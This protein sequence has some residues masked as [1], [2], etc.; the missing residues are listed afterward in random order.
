MRIQLRRGTATA[1]AV[2]NPT[3]AIG[4]PGFE[5]N[6][7][8]FKIGDGATAWAD[9]VYA[10]VIALSHLPGGSYAYRDISALAVDEVDDRISGL[11][12]GTTAQNLF[13]TRNDGA[14]S[15]VRSLTHFAADVDLTSVSVYASDGLPASTATLISPR[16]VLLAHH[17]VP[18]DGTVLRFVTAAD[19]V[20]LR[21]LSTSIRVGTTDIRIGRL[22]SDIPSALGFA[23]VLTPEIEARIL[24]APA[25]YTDQNQQ[26]FVGDITSLTANYVQFSQ[27]ST[28]PRSA[29]WKS[30][31]LAS[32]DSSHPVFVILDGEAVL[33]GA[34]QNIISPTVAR[35]PTIAQN[36]AAINA[37]MTTLGGGYQLTVF[38]AHGNVAVLDESNTFTERQRFDNGFDATGASANITDMTI[39]GTVTFDD[40]LSADSILTVAGAVLTPFIPAALQSIRRNAGNTAF[41]AF[42][43]A[44]LTTVP[45][46]ATATG[47]AGQF[48]YDTSYLYVCVATNTWRRVA[49]ASW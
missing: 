3:L 4:E 7:G 13:S 21:T 41:E 5:T 19:A 33:L 39:A 26:L 44:A 25:I 31:G 12:A 30:G 2:A 49:I 1:W 32:G 23:K 9:L 38:A 45:A 20:V 15:Y 47:T 34:A 42:T 43:P 28:S 6:T 40:V 8:K 17:A 35:A 16:H 29:L 36:I 10:G 18:A 27:A 37:V 11:S 46:N 24:N 22:D 48:A 14:S